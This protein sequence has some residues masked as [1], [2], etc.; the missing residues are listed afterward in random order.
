MAVFNLING[1]LADIVGAPTLLAISGLTF[2]GAILVSIGHLPL[3]RLFTH[4][5]VAAY[6][7]APA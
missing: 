5:E 1:T 3:R 6:A 4:G 2:V 7:P